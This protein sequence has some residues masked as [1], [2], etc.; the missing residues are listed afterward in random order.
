MQALLRPAVALEEP[1]RGQHLH[2]HALEMGQRDETPGGIAHRGGV[3][4]LGHTE[5]PLVLPVRTGDAA[6]DVDVLHRGQPLQLELG[7]ASEPQALGDHGVEA[8]VEQVFSEALGPAAE[9]E[10]LQRRL[11]LPVAGGPEGDAHPVQGSAP[12]RGVEGRAHR[13]RVFV[14]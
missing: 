4:H 14:R 10:E 2:E 5:D 6:E 11:P 8:P 12:E 9:G 13:L 7:Q 1:D 3:T